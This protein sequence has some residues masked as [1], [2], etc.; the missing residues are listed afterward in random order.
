MGLG[1]PQLVVRQ[2]HFQTKIYGMLLLKRIYQPGNCKMEVK[3][4]VVENKFYIQ[5]KF[6]KVLMAQT[7]SHQLY[8]LGVSGVS[9]VVVLACHHQI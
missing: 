5:R 8:H 6:N 7:N 9:W 2:T 4:D 3:N 1:T